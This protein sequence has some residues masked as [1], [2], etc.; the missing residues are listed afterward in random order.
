M[1]VLRLGGNVSIYYAILLTYK[2]TFKDSHLKEV[3]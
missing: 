3:F 1:K 2:V